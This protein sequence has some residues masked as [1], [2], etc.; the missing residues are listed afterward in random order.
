[1]GRPNLYVAGRRPTRTSP[2]Y[3]CEV[4]H[5][6]NMQSLSNQ[7]TSRLTLQ[8]LDHDSSNQENF[9]NFISLSDLINN[10]TINDENY[11]KPSINMQQA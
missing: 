10:V 3:Y 1:M 11:I 8:H 7:L 2:G 6:V 9:S 5:P 4:A